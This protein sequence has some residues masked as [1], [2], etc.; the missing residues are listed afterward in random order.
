MLDL[1]GIWQCDIPGQIAPIRIPGTL[2]ESHIGHADA[3]GKKWHPDNDTNAALYQT[4]DGIR[5]RLTRVVTYEGAARISRT[6]SYYPTP[7]KRIF[8]DV[9]RSRHLTLEVNGRPVPPCTLCSI[10]T[11]YSFEVTGLLQGEDTITFICDNSYPTWP[12]DAIVF[13]SAAT[14][15]TQTNWNGLLGYVRLREEAPVFLSGVRVYPH[16]TEIDVLV[17]VDA[18]TALTATLRLTSDALAA[19]VEEVVSIQPGVQTL[20]FHHLALRPD[21]RRWDENDGQLYQL[22]ATFADSTQTISFGVRDFCAQNSCLTLNQ[23]RVFLRSEA[24]CAVFPETGYPPMN[25]E[26]WR[27]ILGTYRRY[28]VNCMRFHSHTPPEAAFLAADELGMLMQPELSHWNPQTAF[29]DDASLRY[30]TDE[31]TAILRHLANHPSFVMMTFGNELAS[32]DIGHQRMEGL[33]SLAHTLDSTRLFACASNPHYGW[34]GHQDSSDF[35]TSSNLRDLQL[36]ATYAEMQGYLNHDAPS[37]CHDYTAA[38]SILRQESGKPFISFEVGQYEV[39]PD[40]AEIDDFTGVTRAVNLDY[41]RRHVREKGMLDTW[42][43]QV[44]ATGES[45]LLCYREEVEAALRT[46]GYSGISLL[47]L[48]DFPGQGTAL[49]GMLNSHLCPKPYAFAQ[50]ERFHAFFR[51][52]LPLVR[53]PKYTYEAE[54]MLHAPV[55]LSN[56]SREAVSGTPCWT[57]E[58]NGVSLRGRMPACHVPCG[59]LGTLGALSIALPAITAPAELTLTVTINSHRNT[60]PL[61]VY[62]AV[63]PICPSRVH[64]CRQLDD[65]ALAVL[66]AGGTVYLSPDSTAEALPTSVQAQ[67]SPDFW[68][69]GTFPKQSGCMGQLID[70]AHPIFRSFPTKRHST[71]QWW[72][73]ANQR[74]MVLPRRMACIIAEMDSYAYLRPMAQLLE[75][76][77]GGGHLLVSSLGLH[78]LQAYPEARALQSAVYRYLDEASAPVQQEMTVEEVRALVR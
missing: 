37:A 70:D 42:Q 30:Y 16:G 3:G 18:T 7:G 2:D 73:L 47:G 34:W 6:L 29:E 57:L 1:Q 9:E 65:A 64:E 21:V 24:N 15:E 75:C 56:Y 26:S 67:F 48:Q 61:Y 36:R 20:S 39:L 50:P 45:A 38:L 19:P 27:E 76:R 53:L 58:G 13:S 44:E 74:A 4:Q 28:G 66:A 40:F 49:V 46:E 78:Q 62:P 59:T 12:H 31:L 33:L 32:G 8:L 54:E 69:V 22:T 25:V 23:R 5:T 60:Y 77:C 14:D 71:W 43:R 55:L 51:D 41:I 35:Y 63:T 68:S 11:P 52:V 10:S 72:H 17:D